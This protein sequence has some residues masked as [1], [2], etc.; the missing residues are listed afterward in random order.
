MTVIAEYN[1]KKV[2]DEQLNALAMNLYHS[3]VKYFESEKGSKEFEEY[4]LK[5]NNSA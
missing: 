5:Q 2:T 4:L 1:D 3:M